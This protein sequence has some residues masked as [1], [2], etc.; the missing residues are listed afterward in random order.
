MYLDL[1]NY[2]GMFNSKY[3]VWSFTSMTS[4]MISHFAKFYASIITYCTFMWFFMG[5]LIPNMSNKFSCNMNNCNYFVSKKSVLNM[6]L[7]NFDI[8]MVLFHKSLETT[9]TNSTLMRT[10]FRMRLHMTRQQISNW[11]FPIIEIIYIAS[12]GI[13]WIMFLLYFHHFCHFVVLLHKVH[14]CWFQHQLEQELLFD[15]HYHLLKQQ[16]K[17]PNIILLFVLVLLRN[18]VYQLYFHCQRLKPPTLCESHQ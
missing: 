12:I 6:H 13:I 15:T 9:F 7:D 8:D 4:H 2:K 17:I 3:L 18:F 1:H 10:F 11:I 14:N 5:M 16:S